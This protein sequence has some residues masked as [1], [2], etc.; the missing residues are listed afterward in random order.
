MRNWENIGHIVLRT[1]QYLM[2]NAK[3]QNIYNLIGRKEYNI[4]RIV[5]LL[6]ILNIALLQ[7]KKGAKKME[8]YLLKINQQLTEST[9]A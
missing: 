6:S 2:L 5:F 9:M 3:V 8:I 1:V 4:G 7:K